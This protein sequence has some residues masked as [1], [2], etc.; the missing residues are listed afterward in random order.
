RTGQASAI[1]VTKVDD[2]TVSYAGQ[3][4]Y[5]PYIPQLLDYQVAVYVPKHVVTGNPDHW[6]D[7]PEGAIPTGPS[8]CTNG[9]HG[10]QYQYDISPKYNGPHKPGIQTLM[11]QIAPGG[12]D[13][14]PGFLNE[15]I[16]LIHVLNAQQLSAARADPRLS[17]LIHFFPNFQSTYLQLDT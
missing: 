14:F 3:L 15:E 6:A 10:K 2:R 12:A 9:D 17:P 1:G 16:D 5:V 4:G 8:I 7:Q 11:T 13:S